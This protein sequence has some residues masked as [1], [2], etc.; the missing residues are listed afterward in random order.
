M[1]ARGRS[2]LRSITTRGRDCEPVAGETALRTTAVGPRHGVG[3]ASSSLSQRSMT[4]RGVLIA[5]GTA[6]ANGRE[7]GVN[8]SESEKLIRRVS[9]PAILPLSLLHAGSVPS[10]SMLG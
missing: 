1:D 2:S 8:D 10:L 9:S 7:Q 5:C 4:S 6:K 3:A